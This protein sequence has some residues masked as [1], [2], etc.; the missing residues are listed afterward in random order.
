[1]TTKKETKKRSLSKKP[2]KRE[3]RDIPEHSHMKTALQGGDESMRYYWERESNVGMRLAEGYEVVQETDAI[4]S[5]YATRS[6]DH[7]NSTSHYR[8]PTQD[9]NED[10]ILLQIPKDLYEQLEA[11]RQERSD[12]ID[13]Q[14]HPKRWK[15]RTGKWEV[16]CDV[17][18]D[19]K[20]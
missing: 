20:N 18:V 14:L 10:L 15:T 6:Q 3:L 9:S 11:R 7:A 2:A 17:S 12:N 5:A 19:N 16:E 13:R 4:L 1:M 8:I